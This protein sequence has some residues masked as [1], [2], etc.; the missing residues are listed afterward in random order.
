MSLCLDDI[1]L[2]STE[3]AFYSFIE[4][5]PDA[6]L[7]VDETSTIVLANPH[8]LGL[9]G[10]DKAELVGQPIEILISEAQRA[11]HA[12]HV[13]KYFENPTRRMM[14]GSIKFMAVVKDGSSIPVD[15]ML[16]PLSSKGSRIVICVVRD[17]SEDHQLRNELRL[18]LE[19]EQ[20]LARVDP[21]TG[22]VNSRQFHKMLQ[23]EMDRHKR[24]GRPF[25]LAYIDLDNFKKINDQKGHSEGDKALR[26][27]IKCV[28]KNARSTDVVGRMG[29]DEFAILL[30]EVGKQ[31]ARIVL[32]K[33]QKNLLKDMQ[34]NSWPVTFS[35]GLLICQR[36]PE[37]PDDAIK[38][39]DQLMYGIKHNGKNAIA[40]GIY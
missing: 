27:V 14:G 2:N 36:L 4:Y 3:D 28:K 21:L 12:G 35:I 1:S 39:V 40:Y 31:D 30:P 20:V 13:A 6:V 18:Q 10:Y 38:L 17:M 11:S 23:L 8:V 26:S 19:R 33:M 37:T 9:F 15:I 22:A 7:G 32:E 34:A 5:L 24:Y 25:S 16:G 29:G